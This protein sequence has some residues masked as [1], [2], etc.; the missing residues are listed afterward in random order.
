MAKKKAKKKKK[1]AK[2]TPKFQT[3]ESLGDVK[4]KLT[5]NSIHHLGFTALAIVLAGLAGVCFWTSVSLFN[6]NMRGADPQSRGII[7]AVVGVLFAGAAL[8]VVYHMLSS[9]SDCVC[10]CEHGYYANKGGRQVV[11][12]WEDIILMEEVT[13]HIKMPAMPGVLG[14]FFTKTETIPGLLRWYRCDHLECTH[15]NENVQNGHR[16]EIEL[17]RK[18]RE[19]GVPWEKVEEHI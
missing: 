7:V 11:V 19:L 4:F 18:L 1:P 9:F 6:G 13:T 8:Y 5:R 14:F 12:G 16:F 2:Q 10:V 15:P 3:P 17:K